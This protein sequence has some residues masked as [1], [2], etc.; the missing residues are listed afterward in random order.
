RGP[1][2]DLPGLPQRPAVQ[3]HGASGACRALRSR[4]R[5]ALQHAARGPPFRRP[6]AAAGRLRIRIKVTPMVDD[7][8]TKPVLQIFIAST[9]PG[10]AGE[11]VTRW[12][13]PIARA[14]GGFEVDVVDLAEVALPF[15]DEPNHPFMR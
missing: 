7:V 10:R 13:E 15:V 1:E 5:A 14:H 3:L 2:G 9:R 12:V 11:P 4:R 6:A 8:E